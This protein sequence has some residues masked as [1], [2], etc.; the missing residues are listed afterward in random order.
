[1]GGGSSPR[2]PGWDVSVSLGHSHGGEDKCHGWSRSQ[3]DKQSWVVLSDVRHHSFPGAARFHLCPRP[4]K[5]LPLFTDQLGPGGETRRDGGK[6]VYGGPSLVSRALY[7]RHPWVCHQMGLGL[8]TDSHL[9]LV[10]GHFFLV[11]VSSNFP[12]EKLGLIIAIS[13]GS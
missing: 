13:A 12:N 7:C 4:V 9:S 5:Q 8:P 3:G 11:G 1:M 10:Q 2:E 6:E